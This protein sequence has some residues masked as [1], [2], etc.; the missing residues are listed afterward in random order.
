ML[1]RHKEHKGKVRKPGSDNYR[2]LSQETR[3]IIARTGEYK[4]RGGVTRAQEYNLHWNCTNTADAF[5]ILLLLKTP[6]AT[7]A[8]SCPLHYV[9]SAIL[10]VSLSS[11]HQLAIT[12]AAGKIEVSFCCARDSTTNRRK[13][14]SPFLPPSNVLSFSLIGR[15]EWEANRQ[16]VWE[17]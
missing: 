16:G 6:K 15:T 9:R 17:M 4:E 12:T 11:H 5:G 10:T 13:M 1:S 7:G 2:K 14:S 8:C 3:G